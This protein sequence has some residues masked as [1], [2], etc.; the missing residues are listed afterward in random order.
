M[1]IIFKCSYAVTAQNVTI[2][3]LVPSISI[4]YLH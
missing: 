4:I 2:Y 3:K 1:F